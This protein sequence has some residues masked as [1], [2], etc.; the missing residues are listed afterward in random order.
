MSPERIEGGKYGFKSDVWGIGLILY[1]LGMDN[2]I[3]PPLNS[4]MTTAQNSI[5]AE[6]SKPLEHPNF[7]NTTAPLSKIS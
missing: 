1:E 3:Q 2:Y 5:S 4:P 6:I 7:P